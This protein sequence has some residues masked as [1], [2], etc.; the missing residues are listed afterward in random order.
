MHFGLVSCILVVLLILEWYLHKSDQAEVVL[1]LVEGQLEFLRL[2]SSPLEELT[3]TEFSFSPIWEEARCL[4]GSVLGIF[5]A[6]CCTQTDSCTVI[7]VHVMFRLSELSILSAHTLYTILY[8]NSLVEGPS[9][10][11]LQASKKKIKL[12]NYSRESNW[13]E[14]ISNSKRYSGHE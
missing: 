7:E 8:E 1:V 13:K 12:S 3:S 9:H 5:T 6:P 10:S 14:W 11:C 4:K 2:C